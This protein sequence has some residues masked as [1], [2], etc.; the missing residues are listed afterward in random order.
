[1]PCSPRKTGFSAGGWFCFLPCWRFCPDAYSGMAFNVRRKFRCLSLPGNC[2]RG[3][4]SPQALMH[5][6]LPDLIR[7]SRRLCNFRGVLTLRHF[8]RR[9]MPESQCRREIVRLRSRPSS[10]LFLS[11][12]ISPAHGLSWA[13]YIRRRQTRVQLLTLFKE[14]SK[15][16]PPKL[17]PTKP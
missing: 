9:T 5:D 8:G 4:P 1:M 6:G 11:T 17:F 14:L 13:G 15:P 2:Q 7:Y 12:R 16:I 3:Q 10:R